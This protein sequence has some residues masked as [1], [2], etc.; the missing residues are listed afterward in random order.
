MGPKSILIAVG[1]IILTI[2]FVISFIISRIG[3]SSNKKKIDTK[4]PAVEKSIKTADISNDP[5][6][7]DGLNIETESLITDWI[8]ERSFTLRAVPP[9]AFGGRGSELLVISKNPFPLPEKVTGKGIGLGETVNVRVKGRVVILDRIQLENA[10]GIDLDGEQIKLDD[11]DL[12]DWE[13]GS[14]LILESVEKI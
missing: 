8:T 10:L 2:V 6:V 11:N 9:S 1:L 12:E 14:V 4:K 5:L 3:P 13:L 7:Y